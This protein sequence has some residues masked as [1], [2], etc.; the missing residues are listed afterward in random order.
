TTGD[1]RLSPIVLYQRDY[2]PYDHPGFGVDTTQPKLPLMPVNRY[3]YIGF[4]GEH[5]FHTLSN[6]PKIAFDRLR[7]IARDQWKGPRLVLV[8]FVLLGLLSLNAATAFALVC[9]VALFV[10]YLSYG[11]WVEWT[12]YYFEA[13]PPLSLLAALGVW[14]AVGW[15]RERWP[16]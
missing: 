9:S 6:L 13:M 1:W 7:I 5:K 11:H 10:G 14:R 15:L 4:F 3:T 12:I 8:P 2:L 16:G